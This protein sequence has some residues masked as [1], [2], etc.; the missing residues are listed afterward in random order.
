[1]EVFKPWSESSSRT[2]GNYYH[3]V[4][5]LTSVRESSVSS[6]NATASAPV[7]PPGIYSYGPLA[8][9]LLL[10]I[11]GIGLQV[12]HRIR[13]LKQVIT[14]V[15]LSFAVASIPLLIPL[16]NES[17]GM[18]AH[19]RRDR[20]PRNVSI[21]QISDTSAL[22][23]WETSAETIGAVRIR[24]YAGVVRPG[25]IIFADQGVAVR[26]HTAVIKS[27]N[28]QTDY[29]IDIYSGSDWYD[30]SGSPL[31]LKMGSHK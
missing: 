16:I 3:T 9:F 4:N 30:D 29:E 13:S 28:P 7:L 1:M 22:V 18:Q 2:A 14:A 27:L 19:A 11:A 15:L 17:T 20:V 26:Q 25:T 8:L 12:V 24:S 31:K 10:F 23:T 5:A 6:V 21:R